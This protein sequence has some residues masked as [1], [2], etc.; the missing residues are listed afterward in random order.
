MTLLE[1]ELG[2][3]WHLFGLGPRPSRLSVLVRTPRFRA[4]GHVVFLVFPAGSGEPAVVAKTPRL[5]GDGAPLAREA[6][7]LLA[8]HRAAGGSLDSVP[9]VLCFEEWEGR[10]WLLQTALPGSVMTP[11]FVR[12]DVP[13]RASSTDQCRVSPECLWQSRIFEPSLMRSFLPPDADAVFLHD[14]VGTINERV[15]G[16]D[17]RGV[18]IAFGQRPRC[19]ADVGPR[20]HQQVL[21]RGR[22]C[23]DPLRQA[24]PPLQPKFGRVRTHLDLRSAKSLAHA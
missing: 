23:V 15:L 21:R 11:A 5:L 24:L 18:K 10:P 4:S 2:S 6:S 22:V 9:R 17:E 12:S 3:R 19:P 16:P 20:R 1:E 8:L 13:L 14:G 7:H